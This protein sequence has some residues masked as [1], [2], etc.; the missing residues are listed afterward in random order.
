MLSVFEGGLATRCPSCVRSPMRKFFE[1]D[2]Y[3]KLVI[4]SFHKD[5]SG[6]RM[7]KCLCDYGG[8]VSL[9]VG[10]FNRPY[11]T[12]ESPKLCRGRCLGGTPLVVDFT[13]RV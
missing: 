10:L 1:G 9:F 13:L 4:Q 12:Q 8:T 7:A 5:A 6:R 11:F 3:G 2:R